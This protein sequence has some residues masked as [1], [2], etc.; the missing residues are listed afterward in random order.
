MTLKH[1]SKLGWLKSEHH[2]LLREIA[3][4]Q[5]WWESHDK[6]Q[7]PNLGEMGRRVMN[8]HDRLA[9]HFVREEEGG[10]LT[11]AAEARPELTP[12]VAQLLKDHQ[13]FRS[14]TNELADKLACGGFR[15][16]SWEEPWI[17]VQAILAALAEHENVENAVLAAAFG[18]NY[19]DDEEE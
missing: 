9:S 18:E 16:V 8:L 11:K 12:K 14:R 7:V 10:C 13:E 19:R 3:G 4:L 6:A 2:D 17:E 1:S 15:S 5:G